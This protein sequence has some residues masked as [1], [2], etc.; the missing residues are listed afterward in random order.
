MDTLIGSQPKATFNTQPTVSPFQ[1]S[2]LPDVYSTLLNTLGA[3][4]PTAA[5][6]SG[7]ATGALPG[8]LNYQAP[9]VDAGTAF[10]TGVVQPVTQDFLQRTLPATAGAFG[11]SAGGAF[12]SESAQARSNAAT[13]TSRALAQEGSQFT[14]STNLANQAAANQAAQVRNAALGL[15]PSTAGITS[16]AAQP[17]L[18]DLIS[19]I[20]SPTQT[21]TGI[22][23]GGST[24]LIQGLLSAAGPAAGS[25]SGI[26]VASAL[27]LI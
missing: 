6:V 14:L 21:T 27:G 1:A 10:D 8:Q 3:T 13:D 22:G 5:A 19:L 11:R 12:G 7:E 23:T 26:A 16:T 4:A 25:A 24:G 15:A 9:Q 20:L 17:T 2:T 18:Q